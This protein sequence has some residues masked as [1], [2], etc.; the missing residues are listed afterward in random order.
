M[1]TGE[2]AERF[3]FTYRPR[4]DELLE[5]IRC[6]GLL[7]PPLLLERQEGRYYQIVCGSRRVE[8]LSLLGKEEADA[9][10]V[11]EHECGEAH[12][13][14]WSV[15]DNRFYR[16]F[17]E[18]ERAMLF[19]RLQ[20]SLSGLLPVLEDVLG[21]ELRPP[22]DPEVTARYRAVLSLPKEIK[23]ALALD[24][25]T[26]GHTLLLLKSPEECRRQLFSWIMECTLNTN[27]AREAIQGAMEVA[28]RER[29]DPREYLTSPQFLE[30]LA[31]RSS[32]RHKAQLLLQRI[33]AE[34]LPILEQWRFRFEEAKK[35][36]HLSK[37]VQ[38]L[39]DP[40]FETARL[41]FQITA[42]SEAELNAKFQQVLNAIDEGRVRDLFRS[43]SVER[44]HRGKTS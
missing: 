6:M 15:L 14:R 7:H 28:A 3:L 17:N 40:F 41:T 37:W 43:L 21:E 31:T 24:E 13:F 4:L 1:R 32:P 29:M 22:K 39:H 27:E 16:G 23:D 9:F 36:A 10:V 34:R 20:D 38:I 42:T 33:R 11:G 44:M 12:C 18:I 8:A 19:V 35:N 2:E 30:I 25:I 26:L 5:S